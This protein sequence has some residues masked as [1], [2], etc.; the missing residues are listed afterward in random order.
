MDLTHHTEY[1]PVYLHHQR[2]AQDCQ[3]AV[4]AWQASGEVLPVAAMDWQW[5]PI[6]AHTFVSALSQLFHAYNEILWQE[7]NYCRECGG[8]CCV[9]DASDVR[10]FDLIAIALLGLMSPRLPPRLAAHP[11][12]CIYLAGS[13]CTWP[14][15]WR[16]IKCWSFYCLGSGPWPATTALGMLYQAVTARLQVVVDTHLPAPLALYERR[17][18]LKFTDHLADPVDFSNVLHSACHELLVMPLY[19]RFPSFTTAHVSHTQT[20]RTP[21]FLMADPDVAEFITI[22]TEELYASSPS[23]PAGIARSADE[24]L[25]DLDT[26][27]WIIENQP[28][29]RRQLLAELYAH[30]ADAPVPRKGEPPSLWCGMRNQL[31]TLLNDQ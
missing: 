22:A 28:A 12:D 15:D 17:H 27:T 4:T 30:Y 29:H 19:A 20:S 18:G 23:A 9:V 1:Q 26:L 6:T 11:H 13:Q 21:I 10:P 16:T 8:Q 7:F 3:A 2:L 24:L 25:I 5:T 14:A 31:L